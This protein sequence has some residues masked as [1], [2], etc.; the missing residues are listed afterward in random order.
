MKCN[1]GFLLC[2]Q[3]IS[4]TPA[5]QLATDT[6]P[7]IIPCY[8]PVGEGSEANNKLI[9]ATLICCDTAKQGRLIILSGQV[10][11]QLNPLF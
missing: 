8:H 2:D 7:A 4:L 6:A 9:L 10:Q 11:Q 3:R 1:S 5:W